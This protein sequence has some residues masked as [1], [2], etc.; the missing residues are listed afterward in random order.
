LKR[1]FLL[2]LTIIQIFSL[3]F[4]CM[5]QTST[6]KTVQVSGDTYVKLSDIKAALGFDYKKSSTNS[7][8]IT[9]KGSN[10]DLISNVTQSV[11]AI[12]GEDKQM[13]SEVVNDYY[14]SKIPAGLMHGS[15]VIASKDGRI[16]TN[17]HVVETMKEIY[18]VLYNNKSYKAKLLYRNEDLDLALIKIN[19]TNLKPIEF[20]KMGN[21]NAGDEVIAIGT[22]L[23]FG[24]SNSVSKGVISGL[25][26]PVDETYTFL[27]TDASI[28]PGNSGG[29][30][31]NMNGKLV[32]INTL[33]IEWFQGINFSIPVENV[34]YFI[35]QYNKY[36]KVKRCFTGLE[37]EESWLALVGIPSNQ[38]LKI[39]GIKE[40]SIFTKD[41]VK[42]GDILESIDKT[43]VTSIASYN[44]FLKKKL[45]GQ[46]VKLAFSRGS[47]KFAVSAKLKD[48][49]EITTTP[50]TTPQ[51]TKTVSASNEEV[52]Q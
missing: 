45:P 43:P 6:A 35:Q 41:Q 39:I 40:N 31:I 51:T 30:L 26:R 8:T 15:G 16:I 42:E 46:T 12:I 48:Y 49:P 33:G 19:C 52:P 44:E 5:A 4:S 24:W 3:P 32:G 36:G 7:I 1:S 50:K 11:V 17:N 38:G 23:Y 37:F 20:E 28:N 22:P 47:T 27:Q 14:Y 9:K 2:L 13:N 18:V 29:P 25:N 21:I 34:E 10:K